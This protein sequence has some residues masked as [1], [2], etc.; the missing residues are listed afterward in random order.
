MSDERSAGRARPRRRLATLGRQWGWILAV[1]LVGGFI[2]AVAVIANGRGAP[3]RK[4]PDAASV[5]T[6]S[7]VAASIVRPVATVKG[8][9][10]TRV[11][12]PRP[13]VP[14]GYFSVALSTLP[15]EAATTWHLVEAGG[16]F[17]YREDGAAFDNHAKVLPERPLGWYRQYTVPTPG[18]P[19]R[20]VR[21]LVVGQDTAAFWSADDS[22]SFVF[23][24]VAR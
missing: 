12:P 5:T 18:A 11:G 20:G 10:T 19:D 24:D 22:R 4:V 8:A 14:S 13:S 9:T 16:P 1:L 2:A 17:P 7:T 3:G 15:P 6:V 21:R 23:V